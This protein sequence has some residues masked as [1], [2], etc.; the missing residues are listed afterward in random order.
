VLLSELV[1]LRKITGFWRKHNFLVI[2]INGTW[3]I[4][5]IQ[6]R[7]PIKIRATPTLIAALF[8]QIPPATNATI[9]ITVN[10]SVMML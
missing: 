9:P 5:F 3:G 7:A 6:I 1:I 8:P 4:G 10:G 2:W